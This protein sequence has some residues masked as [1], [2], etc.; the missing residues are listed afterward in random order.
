MASKAILQFATLSLLMHSADRPL[1]CFY[2]LRRVG[3]ILLILIAL[4]PC[5]CTPIFDCQDKVTG[6]FEE[7]AGHRVISVVERDC[8]A[9]TRITTLVVVHPKSKR[10]N[11][12]RDVILAV[13]YDAAPV[14]IYWKTSTVVMGVS[15]SAEL[16]STHP[17]SNLRIDWQGPGGEPLVPK[18][19]D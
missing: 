19:S 3:M 18:H 7:P 8:G 4:V 6:R 10:P 14:T 2:P 13:F 12:D 9:T 11:P 1:Q 17:Q 15:S 5:G 16:S